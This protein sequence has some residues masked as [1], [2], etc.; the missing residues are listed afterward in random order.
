MRTWRSASNLQVATIAEGTV[1]GRFDDF[2][3]ALSDGS[4]F[5]YRLK[6]SSRF[7]RT[8]GVAAADLPV[9]GRDLVLVTREAAVEWAGL[10]RNVVE[11]RA[12]ASAW[13]G[14]RVMSRGGAT[15]GSVDDFLFDAAPPRVTGFLLDRGRLLRRDD[16]VAVGRDAVVIADPTLLVTLDDDE[17]ETT[18]WWTRVRGALGTE[19]KQG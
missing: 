4:I 16:R 3:F 10:P 12:W 6:G 11:G 19:K 13:R 7:A 15:V 2:Q 1:V 14:T 18:D 17:P 9:V 8:G 5:G